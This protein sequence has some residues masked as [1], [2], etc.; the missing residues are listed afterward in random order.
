MEHT[1]PVT[2]VASLLSDAWTMRII[3]TL[4]NTRAMRFCDL[5]RALAGISTRTLTIKLTTLVEKG[6]LFKTDDGYLLTP[7]GK[8]LKPVLKAMETFG[9]VME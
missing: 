2:A 3:H 5:E 4:M 9:K 6:I 7:M 1:C 8:K